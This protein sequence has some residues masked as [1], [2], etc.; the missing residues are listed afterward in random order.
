MAIYSTVTFNGVTLKIKSM[1][2]VRNQKKVKQIVGKT[3]SQLSII[4]L[5]GQQWELNMDGMVFGTTSA[6][7][8]TNRAAIEALDNTTAY[9]FVDGIHNGTFIMLP[10]SLQFKD[11]GDNAGTHYTYSFKLVEK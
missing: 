1:T 6:N 4:G 3:L 11:S 9:A 2:P 8:G 5:A 7:L 10:G